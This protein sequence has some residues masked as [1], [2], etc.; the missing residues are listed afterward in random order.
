MRGSWEV[1]G[2]AESG[3]VEAFDAKAASMDC[4]MVCSAQ[5]GEVVWVVGAS[6]R[7]GVQRRTEA[8]LRDLGRFRPLRG[9]CEVASG[10]IW[11]KTT[12]IRGMRFARRPPS[13]GEVGLG[14]GA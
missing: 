14:A 10:W 13:G 12:R 5:G 9:G 1:P 4:V 8:H 3:G 2:D 6:L 11:P 7:T